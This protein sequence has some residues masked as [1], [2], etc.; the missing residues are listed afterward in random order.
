[1]ASDEERVTMARFLCGCVDCHGGYPIGART[2][3]WPGSPP[4]SAGSLPVAPPRSCLAPAVL[5]ELF[6]REE[7][8]DGE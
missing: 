4:A 1:M 5:A 3:A 8:S 2:L 6:R 7:V